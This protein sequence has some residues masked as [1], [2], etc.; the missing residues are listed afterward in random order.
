MQRLLTLTDHPH[1]PVKSIAVSNLGVIAMKS[2][3]LFPVA[4]LLNFLEHENPKIRQAAGLMLSIHVSQPR[5]ATI[6]S[7]GRD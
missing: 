2:P 7:A 5:S 4:R 6:K 1:D 3:D